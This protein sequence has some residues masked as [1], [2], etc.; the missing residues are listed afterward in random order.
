VNPVGRVCSV[1]EVGGSYP[2]WALRAPVA[3]DL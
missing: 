2:K 1:A 3:A